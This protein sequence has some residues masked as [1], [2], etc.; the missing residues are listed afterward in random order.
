MSD[1]VKTVTDSEFSSFLASSP[2]A[3]VDLW[4]PWCG[5]CRM[6]API[7]DQVADEFAGKVAVGKLNVDENGQTPAKFSV[8]SIPTILFF[9]N[10][11]LVETV[12]G[13]VAKPQ[14]VAKIQQHLGA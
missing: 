12:V 6:I 14:L 9:K 11:Q 2:L 7:I 4:A 10:G 8:R 1:N 13:A 3:I 5:P